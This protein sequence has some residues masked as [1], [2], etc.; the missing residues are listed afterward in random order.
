MTTFFKK[1]AFVLSM[2]IVPLS[3]GA[4]YTFSVSVEINGC[5]NDIGSNVA[6]EIG[7]QM[8]EQYNHDAQAGYP[9]LQECNAARNHFIGQS[10]NEG[11]CRI[12]YMATPC[13]GP[14]MVTG[15]PGAGN[16]DGSDGV[17]QQLGGIDR[18]F[19]SANPV[20]EVNNWNQNVELRDLV[21]NQKHQHLA[22]APAHQPSGDSEFD[23]ARDEY[24]LSGRM[25][26]SN[27]L[28][29]II[30]NGRI[31]S[32][33][34][35]PSS[36]GTVRVADDF[37]DRIYKGT[38]YSSDDLKMIDCDKIKPVNPLAIPREKEED[39]TDFW[40]DDVVTDVLKTA[41][42]TA[43]FLGVAAGGSA[44]IV[45]VGGELA[46]NLIVEDAKAFYKWHKNGE[47]ITTN[48]ILTNAVNKSFLGLFDSAQ[49]ATAEKIVE[50][51]TRATADEMNYAS[52][53]TG[54][55]VT[56]SKYI[57]MGIDKAANPSA[58]QP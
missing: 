47:I 50:K 12:R 17:G 52:Y 39:H 10:F 57:K 6:K 58:R 30:S 5:G 18:S 37:A 31:E 54:L 53:G 56:I 33:V 11:A 14:A 27:S 28:E 29:N 1:T 49:H 48:Q 16:N 9:S 46:I 21:L 4:Q 40:F 44:A 51:T 55:A 22:A 24:V 35:T 43:G 36:K 3:A 15:I 42:D 41:W 2:C 38:S 26:R 25:P 34:Y 45:A 7:K 23:R 13:N 32:V 8:A 19:Y 20:S